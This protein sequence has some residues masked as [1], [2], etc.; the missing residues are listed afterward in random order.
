MNEAMNVA[1]ITYAIAA[2]ISFFV[3]FIIISMTSVVKL[4][5][6]KKESL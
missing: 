3:A 5:S 1:L 4:F 6:K 2:V